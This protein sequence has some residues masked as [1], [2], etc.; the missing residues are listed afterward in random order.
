MVSKISFQGFIGGQYNIYLTTRE[1]T[2]QI[3]APA[4]SKINAAKHEAGHTQP[5]FHH[6]YCNTICK[7]RTS[8]FEHGLMEKIAK[9]TTTQHKIKT[10]AL[11][12]HTIGEYV[13]HTVV[14]HDIVDFLSFLL[15]SLLVWNI[16][17][18]L[19]MHRT[20]YSEHITVCQILWKWQQ[21]I[22]LNTSKA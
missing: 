21:N 6:S 7:T 17:W 9:N 16:A 11:S 19:V 15:P 4:H 8:M 14:M 10:K 2:F 5:W 18:L 20:T 1:F 22:V 3:L 12:V 13:Y